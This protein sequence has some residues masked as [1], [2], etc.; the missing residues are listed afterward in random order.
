MEKLKDSEFKLKDIVWAKAKGNP[1]WPG[2][3]KKISFYNIPKSNQI[4]KEKIF[5]IDFI[6]EKSHV[7]LTKD[8]IELFLDNY[9]KHFSAKQPS[10]IRSIKL[11]KKMCDKNTLVG[12][13]VGVI[14]PILMQS[15][16]KTILKFF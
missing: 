11:A 4:V 13:F 14:F 3:I 15:Y 8:N 1:W 7:K 6:G 2:I 5:T 10:L 12:I 16:I 9:K